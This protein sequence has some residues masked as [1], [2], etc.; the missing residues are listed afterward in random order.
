M[1]WTTK[2]RET[3]IVTLKESGKMLNRKGLVVKS[4]QSPIYQLPDL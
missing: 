2:V 3:G 4:V 1:D